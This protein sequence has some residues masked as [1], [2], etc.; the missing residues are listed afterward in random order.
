GEA[1]ALDGFIEV[2]RPVYPQVGGP[3]DGRR[4]DVTLPTGATSV[5]MML[6]DVEAGLGLTGWRIAAPGAVQHVTLPDLS[7]D[8]DTALPP[9]PVNITVQAAHMDGFNYGAV[10]YRQLT[11]RGWNAY[12][13][14]SFAAHLGR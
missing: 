13:V 5:D 2:P 4:I 3:W 9:G 14:D 10:R 6:Y 1:I 7:S 12:A 11:S 8:P